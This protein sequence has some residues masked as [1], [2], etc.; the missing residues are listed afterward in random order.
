MIIE[1]IDREELINNINSSLE[2]KWNREEKLTQ[3]VENSRVNVDIELLERFSIDNDESDDA[4]YDTYDEEEDV[5]EEQY[6]EDDEDYYEEDTEEYEEDTEDEYFS[7]EDSEE[8]E[9]D[10]EYADEEEEYYEDEEL[11]GSTI[12]IGEVSDDEEESDYYEDEYEDDEVEEYGDNTDVD[13]DED[14][15]Y[16]DD[17]LDDEEI[18]IE[19]IEEDVVNKKSVTTDT[20]EEAN[21]YIESSVREKVDND[22]YCKDEGVI[23]RE[24]MGLKEFLKANKSIRELRE[25]TK[26]F[27]GKDVDKALNSG[28]IM[29]RKG[30]I[31]I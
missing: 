30:R 31:I 16:E 15:E 5:E 7:V 20:S 10:D 24:G 3:E 13:E 25:V 29:L 12:D 14:D 8:D 21:R 11:K 2:L 19:E 18:D 9:E 1:G 23:Y 27:S 22:V 26:Y 17:D 4:E 6:E 28:E